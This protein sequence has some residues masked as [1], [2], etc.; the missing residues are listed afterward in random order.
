MNIG[1]TTFMPSGY[2]HYIGIARYEEGL[3]PQL[4]KLGIDIEPI[5][6]NEK[7][8]PVSPTINRI[9]I[10]LKEQMFGMKKNHDL[11]HASSQFSATRY[12]DV[13][14]VHDMI[15][16]KTDLSLLKKSLWHVCIP[17]LRRAKHI[18]SVSNVTKT[19]LVSIGLDESKITVIHNG[20]DTKKFYPAPDKEL[21]EKFGGKKTLLFVGEFRKYKNVKLLFDSL[22]YLNMLYNE[23]DQ[24]KLILVSKPSK[25]SL[26]FWNSQHYFLKYNTPPLDIVWLK[27][28]NDDMLRK[29]YS[30]VD[31]FV[32]P[33]LYE[34]FGFPPLEAMACGTNVVAID[35]AINREILQDKAFLAKNDKVDFAKAIHYAIENKR[36]SSKLRSFAKR[37]S[38]EE[39]AR[40]V[41]EVYETISRV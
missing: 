40:R 15:G 7:E 18:I 38:W 41:K 12:T 25:V 30:T 35:N 5:Y 13:V 37:Y 36:P 28:V 29:L 3:I 2:I 11:V 32:F 17:F 27:E 24:Y 31:L 10:Y 20:I 8:I 19:D 4:R 39:N 14:T 6:L 9:W 1:M 34:G 23:G 16:L 26:D 22:V 21:K 33:S